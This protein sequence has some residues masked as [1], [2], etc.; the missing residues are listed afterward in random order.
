MFAYWN[1][2]LTAEYTNSFL[3]IQQRLYLVSLCY[4]AILVLR[5]ENTKLIKIETWSWET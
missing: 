5:A 3:I 2:A 4:I 1:I